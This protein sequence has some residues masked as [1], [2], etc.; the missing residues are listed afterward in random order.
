MTLPVKSLI[1]LISSNSSRSPLSTNQANESSWSSIRFG[2]SNFSWL[3]PS[4]FLSMRAY[5]MRPDGVR[6]RFEDSA[7]SMKHHSLTEAEGEG[8]S[9]T[10]RRSR[11]PRFG[12]LSNAPYSW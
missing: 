10:H 8:E 4:I 7:D 11:I 6:A 9:Q 3:T 12:I 2:I 1:G 5:E